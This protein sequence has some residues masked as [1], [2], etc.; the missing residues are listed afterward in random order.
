MMMKSRSFLSQSAR[1][2]QDSSLVLITRPARQP[3]EKHV[4][5][6]STMRVIQNNWWLDKL[7]KSLWP[8]TTRRCC[9][10]TIHAFCTL[11]GGREGSHSAKP[12]QCSD[13]LLCKNKEREI[14]KLQLVRHH[15]SFHCREDPCQSPS[16]QA[17][18]YHRWRSSPGE[19]VR[20]LS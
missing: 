13:S 6:Q 18:T 2:T 20:L 15:S 19:P 14:W 7:G 3:T 4:T 5:L 12:L 17:V 9:W 11:L 16:W 10:T 8:I 1:A